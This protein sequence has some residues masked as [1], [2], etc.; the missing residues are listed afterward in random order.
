[1]PISIVIE[2]FE[3]VC[4]PDNRESMGNADH[5]S[6]RALLFR[7]VVC[8]YLGEGD[9]GPRIFV[10]FEDL[11]VGGMSHVTFE[12]V[13]VRLSIKHLVDV[14]MLLRFDEGVVVRVL[15]VVFLDERLRYHFVNADT[16]SLIRESG[17]N[18]F[19]DMRGSHETA[20]KG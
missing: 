11:W 20:E 9:L 13:S 3:F 1:M 8:E 15:V 6:F 19:P 17:C 12:L 10:L 5:C 2:V 16:G 7:E 4:E 14:L 18:L